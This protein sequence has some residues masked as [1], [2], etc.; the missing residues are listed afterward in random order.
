VENAQEGLKERRSR[1]GISCVC[2]LQ[3][4]EEEEEEEE[5]EYFIFC[6]EEKGGCTDTDLGGEWR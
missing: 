3:K 1:E 4:E 2:A 5:Q 6:D